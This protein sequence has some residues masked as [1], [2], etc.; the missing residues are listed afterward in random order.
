MQDRQKFLLIAAA[1]VGAFF[2][3]R[4]GNAA[5]GQDQAATKPG[6]AAFAPTNTGSLLS[7][8]V[9][10]VS[11]A[12]APAPSASP[13]G[14]LINASSAP[15]GTPAA[16]LDNGTGAPAAAAPGP[17]ALASWSQPWMQFDAGSGGDG[18]ASGGD[19]DGGSSE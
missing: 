2:L 15:Y 4:P 8:L 14:N 10:S 3:L 11:A 16:V 7:R 9:G 12:S 13:W 17:A 18:G 19:G 5:A 1:A 6:G